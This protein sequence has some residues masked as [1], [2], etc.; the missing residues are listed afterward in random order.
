M[1]S[2]SGANE[3]Y[4]VTNYVSSSGLAYGDG[5]YARLKSLM[6]QYELPDKLKQKAHLKHFQVYMEGENLL[7]ITPYFGYD[8]ESQSNYMPPARVWTF[9]L[10]MGL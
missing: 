9:G 6:L 7:T 2:Q 1:F 3:S 4:Y 10:R 8:P 5:S